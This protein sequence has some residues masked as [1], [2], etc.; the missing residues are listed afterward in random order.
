MKNVKAKKIYIDSIPVLHIEGSRPSKGSIIF[1]HGWEST[2]SNQIFR[3]RIMA[4]DGY[5]VYLPEAVHHGERKDIDYTKPRAYLHFWD[6][7]FK[8]MEEAASLIS[9]MK[10]R[11]E[12]L[13]AVGGHSMGAFSAMGIF[14]TY[15]N[16]PALIALNGSGHW[17][18]S[19]EE[20]KRR[21]GVEDTLSGL[22]NMELRIREQDPIKR[23]SCVRNRSLL[24]LNGA[25]DDVVIPTGQMYFYEQARQC[26]DKG[27][28]KSKQYEGVGHFVTTNM[29]EEVGDFLEEITSGKAG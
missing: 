5:D 10:N 7:I 29:M 28:L 8:N 3:A 11:K 25:A 6:T 4:M 21:R 18:Q 15:E 16:I 13:L 20:F 2:A 26:I 22:K 23:L 19:N 27:L 17:I 14:M 1:Y 9:Y 12:H 24:L